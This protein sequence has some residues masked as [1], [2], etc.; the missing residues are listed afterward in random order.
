MLTNRSFDIRSLQY[1]YICYSPSNTSVHVLPRAIF[2]EQ[3]LV[4]YGKSTP[5][6]SYFLL[7]ASQ[8]FTKFM[9]AS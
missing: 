7:V 1:S 6:A 5:F 3:E 2:R 9:N 4:R 8:V